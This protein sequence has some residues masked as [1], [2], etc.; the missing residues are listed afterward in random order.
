MEIGVCLLFTGIKAPCCSP[1]RARFVVVPRYVSSSSE[2][3]EEGV[4]QRDSLAPRRRLCL[5]WATLESQASPF[6]GLGGPGFPPRLSAS[7]WKEQLGAAVGDVAC[8]KGCLVGLLNGDLILVMNA[9][10]LNRQ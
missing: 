7:R 4:S 1:D 5:S 8:V 2:G 6:R 9:A 3:L 10:V